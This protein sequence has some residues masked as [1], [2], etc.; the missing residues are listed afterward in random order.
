MIIGY[1]ISKYYIFVLDGCIFICILDVIRRWCVRFQI[2][3]IT[4]SFATSGPQLEFAPPSSRNEPLR[5]M[6][7]SYS[8]D[9]VCLRCT[10]MASGKRKV[11]REHFDDLQSRWRVVDNVQR[12]RNAWEQVPCVRRGQCKQGHGCATDDSR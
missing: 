11:N 1:K 3:R 4:S 7:S 12:L 8:Q 5:L 6:S 10:T 2:W 9:G